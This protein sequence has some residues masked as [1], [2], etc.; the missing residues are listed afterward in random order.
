MRD[1]GFLPVGGASPGVFYHPELDAPLMLK[2][3]HS[4]RSG[5]E[6]RRQRSYSHMSLI[7]TWPLVL[8]AAS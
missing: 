7:R 8:R 2:H 4:A 3:K 5:V 1:C 6:L